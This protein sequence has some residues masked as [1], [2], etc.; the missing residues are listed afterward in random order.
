MRLQHLN[1]FWK[2]TNNVKQK[3]KSQKKVPDHIACTN[4]NNFHEECQEFKCTHKKHQIECTQ[5]CQE[6]CTH[7]SHQIEC[8]KN[9]KNC[10][11]TKVSDRMHKEFQEFVHPQKISEMDMDMR[12]KNVQRLL[13]H[14]DTANWVLK[15]SP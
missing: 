15:S 4:L 1:F 2:S 11:P 5:E 13:R 8:T 3:E 10:A 12:C 6:L 9:V 14:T 7:K